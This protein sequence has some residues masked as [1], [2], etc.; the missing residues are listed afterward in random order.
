M[1]GGWSSHALKV[2]PG[3]QVFCIP[4]ALRTLSIRG[5]WRLPDTG[6]IDLNRS[7]RQLNSISSCFPLPDRGRGG[8][9]ES[10]N[11]LKGVKPPVVFG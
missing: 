9:T 10:P 6:V 3:L 11:L 4:E 7:P 8:R 5:L 1:G 2:P